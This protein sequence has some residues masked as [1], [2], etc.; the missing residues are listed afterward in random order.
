MK[1]S[2]S[3]GLAVLSIGINAKELKADL[4]QKA[5]TV[6]GQQDGKADPGQVKSDTSDENFINICAGK[7]LTNGKQIEAGSCNGIPMGDIP[8]KNNMVSSMIIFP[9]TGEPVKAS[10]SFDIKVKVTNMVTGFF[11][12]PLETYYAA[13]QKLE[14]GK[15]VGH[16]HV[17]VQDMGNTM[18]PDTP[19]APDK[20]SFFKGIND[21]ADGNGVLTATVTDGLP[22]GKYRICTLTSAANHQ[23]V[24]MPVAQRGAQDDCT[25]FEV[26]V[27]GGSGGGNK[28]KD[29]KDDDSKNGG[30][31]KAKDNKEDKSKN[32][33]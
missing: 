24:I 32:G 12:N 4:I 3:I 11:T 29:N 17:T 22:I 23:A 8:S 6:T 16:T 27:D 25:K 2:L 1:F 20:F 10:Q 15:V 28:A 19:L 13:P 18:N 30:V 31:N 33:G 26:T 7:T 21:K 14:G 5:S 9:K